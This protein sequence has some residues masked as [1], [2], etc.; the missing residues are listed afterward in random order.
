MTT[1]TTSTTTTTRTT[2]ITYW[3][4]AE[5]TAAPGFAETW[6]VWIKQQFVGLQSA[7]EWLCLSIY[8]LTI[9][10]ILVGMLC[11]LN[12][13]YILY[14]ICEN[15]NREGREKHGLG[16]PWLDF[17]DEKRKHQGQQECPGRRCLY[18]LCHLPPPPCL[19]L[20]FHR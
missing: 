8:F 11:L 12:S 4:E 16:R 10:D 3:Y 9:W 5:T 2:T 19:C 7:A 15:P 17:M 18:N 14:K 13:A 6:W 1:T 20:A